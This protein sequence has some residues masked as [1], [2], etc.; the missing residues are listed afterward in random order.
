MPPACPFP[1][2]QLTE[3]P[4]RIRPLLPLSLFDLLV[5]SDTDSPPLFLY[6]LPRARP[7]R[8]TARANVSVRLSCFTG[9]VSRPVQ[10]TL[11]SFSDCHAKVIPAASACN[12]PDASN[13]TLAPW[14][15]FP[16]LGLLSTLLCK[17]DAVAAPP[18]V[19]VLPGTPQSVGPE[20]LPHSSACVL[21]ML[22]QFDPP[23]SG[24]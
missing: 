4:A 14:R 7:S 16:S 9:R 22:F 5:Y 21:P 11:T 19:G 23:G 15:T 18:A 17:D 3:I 2:F 1:E 8:V 12:T 10:S 20:L 13:E 24:L 6:I